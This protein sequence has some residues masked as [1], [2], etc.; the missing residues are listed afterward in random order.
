[1]TD[2]EYMEPDGEIAGYSRDAIIES[3]EENLWGMWSHFGMGPECALH[4]QGG[5]L[6]FDTPISTLPYNTVLSFQVEDDVVK[7]IDRIFDQVTG[8][9]FD[10]R[11]GIISIETVQRQQGRSRLADPRGHEF[12]SERDDDQDCKAAG[13]LDLQV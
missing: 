7:Q 11:I 12:W 6:R 1:M 8:D 3:L 13:T 4:D 5:V 9:T 2:I 10:D